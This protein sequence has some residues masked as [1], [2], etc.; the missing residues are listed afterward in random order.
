MKLPFI[1]CLSL[2]SLGA[3]QQD[4]EEEVQ[5]EYA[6]WYALRAP[7]DRAIEAVHGDIDGTLLI[8]TGF[9][10]YQTTDRGRT[11]RTA[12]YQNNSGLFGFL[13]LQDTLFVLNTQRGSAF[14]STTAYAIHASHFSLDQGMT[15]KRYM[16]WRR[17]TNS[18]L[19]VARNRA[20]SSS[21]LEYSIDFLLTPTSPQS[22]GSYVETVGIKTSTGKL[23][24]LPQ[25]HQ[26]KSVYFD[27]SSRLYV[28]GSAPLC[29]RGKDFSFCGEQNGMLYVSKK[30]QP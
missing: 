20:T 3:C 22:S 7:D 2:L 28:T 6:D 25:E 11:W 4:S 21:G 23:L 14:D 24:S 30:P 17:H 13:Q 5:P 12:D 16:D 10:I 15:W 27:A 26:L 8:T 9:K 18:E 29:G 19:S 1:F